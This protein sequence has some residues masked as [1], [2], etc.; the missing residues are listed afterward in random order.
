[1]DNLP[2]DGTVRDE[3]KNQIKAVKRFDY[4]SKIYNKL[5]KEDMKK[6]FDANMEKIKKQNEKFRVEEME[7]DM[8]NVYFPE[9]YELEQMDKFIEENDILAKVAQ[10][11]LEKDMEG[12]FFPSN[13]NF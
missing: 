9:K 8:Q 5:T 6:Y 2:D 10:E 4:V 7:R 12:V 13:N 3:Y 11:Q 1:M